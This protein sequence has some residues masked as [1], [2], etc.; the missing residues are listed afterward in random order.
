MALEQET[1]DLLERMGIEGAQNYTADD[2]KELVS[3][4]NNAKN[5]CGDCG[6]KYEDGENR[7]TTCTAAALGRYYDGPEIC[8]MCADKRYKTAR[9]ELDE[10]QRELDQTR[11]DIKY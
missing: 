6:R 1:K 7:V 9:R 8:E 4:I 11:F 10:I 3:L 2:L 5:R